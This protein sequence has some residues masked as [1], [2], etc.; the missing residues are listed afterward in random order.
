M[1]GESRD[2]A[3]GVGQEPDVPW[4]WLDALAAW[5]LSWAG[6][7]LLV[8]LLAAAPRRVA[9]AVGL[10]AGL[11]VLGVAT[12]VWVRLRHPGS[13]RKLL[14]DGPFTGEA[15]RAGIA[16]G[17]LAFVVINLGLSLGLRLLAEYTNIELP[18]VQQQFRA[19]AA[20]R[21][22]APFLVLAAVLVAP[23]AEELFYRGMLF[24]ALRARVGVWPGIMLSAGLFALGH[25]EAGNPGGSVLA[26]LLILPLGA[27]LAWLFQRRG[28][29]AVPMAAH[30][31]FNALTTA[32]LLATAS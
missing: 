16:H 3:R 28:T 21:T 31:T 4:S 19:F 24:Q 32:V 22:L 6:L 23:C 1:G 29:I 11:V 18:Q 2:G 7:L 15:V 30:A 12:V 25:R 10:P 27:Y 13:V 17:L 26:F 20:D 5:L 9:L 8:P 14:G